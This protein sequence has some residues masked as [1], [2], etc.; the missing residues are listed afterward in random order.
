MPEPAG[1]P[2]LV[3]LDTAVL[4][5]WTLDPERLSATAQEHLDGAEE[6]IALSVSLW[7][8]ALK[9]RKG[10]LE[11]P[12]TIGDYRARLAEVDRLRIHYLDDELAISGVLL[13]WAHR[14]PAD[15]WITA[16]AIRLEAPLISSDR[17]IRAYYSRAVW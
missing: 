10:A 13:D 11:L 17:E 4:L 16:L 15:R 6:I 2:D 3:V 14:D 9:H 7:E 8:I 5:Y 1:T 12:G